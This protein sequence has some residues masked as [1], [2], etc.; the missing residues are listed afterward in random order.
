MSVTNILVADLR[1]VN[2]QNPWKKINTAIQTLSQ[3]WE[4]RESKPYIIQNA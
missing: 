3:K 2:S 1:Q 4:P